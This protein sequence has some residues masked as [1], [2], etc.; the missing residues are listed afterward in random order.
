MKKKI[1]ITTSI[2][3]SLVIIIITSFLISEKV[4]KPNKFK[5]LCNSYDNQVVIYNG[6]NQSPINIDN[7]SLLEIEIS[8]LDESIFISSMFSLPNLPI[9]IPPDIL[10]VLLY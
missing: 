4:I 2:I 9:I 3:S 5:E 8:E 7:K 1:I 10:I 6:S